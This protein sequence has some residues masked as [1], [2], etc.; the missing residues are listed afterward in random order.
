MPV[1]VPVIKTALGMV[2]KDFKM[3]VLYCHGR[4]SP[5]LRFAAPAHLK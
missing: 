4:T 2:G 3:N 1:D 5:T